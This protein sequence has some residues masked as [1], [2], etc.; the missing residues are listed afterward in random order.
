MNPT[1]TTSSALIVTRHCAHPSSKGSEQNFTGAVRLD[2]MFL[3]SGSLLT[4]GASVTFEP[5]ARTAWHS[6]PKGQLLIVTAGRGWIKQ[7]GGERQ[8][9]NPGDSVW[10]PPDVRHWHGATRTTAMTHI[11]IT[12]YVDGSN[13]AWMEKVTDEHYLA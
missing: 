9:I 7:E 2:R 3:P 10:I 5:G 13:A 1:N 4:S 8:E 6:H 12:E 11:S